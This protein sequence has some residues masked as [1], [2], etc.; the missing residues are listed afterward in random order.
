[1]D[2][3]YRLD[4]SFILVGG[5]DGHSFLQG[6]LTQDL[7]GLKTGLSQYAA[8]LTPQ[9]KVVADMILRPAR[10]AILIDVDTA[11]ADRV[12]QRLHM[13]Q[14]RSAVN[15]EPD[16][17]EL[18]LGWSKTPFE[19]ALQDPRLPELGWRGFISVNA[20]PPGGAAEYEAHRVALGVPDLARD[21]QPEEVFALEAL[22]EELNGVV[23]DKGCFV[24]QENVSRMKRRATTRKKFCPINF[25]GEAIAY[26]TPVFAGEAELGTVRTGVPGRALALLR[27][28]RAIDA[29]AAGRALTAGGREIALDP[30]AWLMLPQREDAPG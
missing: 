29:V 21:S 18:V 7:N 30:P 19:G 25:A 15:L 10:T 27:L 13:Y 12:A 16:P 11:C 17:P 26:G 14:L 24:G 6:I 23:F 3:L 1:M 2:T 28:D 5:P 22:L 20:S 4:R 9:G 8:L